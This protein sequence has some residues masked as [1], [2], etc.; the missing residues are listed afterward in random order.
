MD[1]RTTWTHDRAE[2]RDL[3][4]HFLRS[5]LTDG[6]QAASTPVET[7]IPGQIAAPLML[8]DGRILAFVV[9]RE[10]PGTMRLWQSLDGGKTWPESSSLL[11]HEH[12]EQ[13]LVTQSGS[14]IDFA[15][16]W[17]DMG[18]WSFGHPSIRLAS[19]QEV[20]VTWYAGT[21]DCMN[22]H[23]ALIDVSS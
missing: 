20:L 3:R 8:A 17:E 19:D 15:E 21:P 6:E 13:A 1:R 23:A 22:V 5:S 4:V 16:Y 2:K 7:S 10:R 14:D 11:V 12:N 18:K 9:N